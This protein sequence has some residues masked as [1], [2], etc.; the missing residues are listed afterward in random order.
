MRIIYSIGHTG[1]T[2]D[3]AHEELLKI[4]RIERYDHMHQY[5]NHCVDLSD[6][7]KTILSMD[8][9]QIGTDYIYKFD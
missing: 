9:S 4:H 7:K 1:H 2:V 5:Y 6:G 3:A 8:D